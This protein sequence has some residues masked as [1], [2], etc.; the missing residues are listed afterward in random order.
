MRAASGSLQVHCARYL[1]RLRHRRGEQLDREVVGQVEVDDRD[2]RL[3]PGH[4]LECHLGQHRER[5]PASREPARHVVARHVLH[6]AAAGLEQLRP[7]VD[8]LDTQQVI[9]RRPAVD[10][11]RARQV[12]G[13]H[14]P[15]RL[16]AVRSAGGGAHVDRLEGEHL[17]A[18]GQLGLDRGERRAGARRHHELARLI[19]GDAAQRGRGDGYGA[20]DGAADGALGTRAHDLDGEALLGAS[21]DH[22]LELPVGS[23]PLQVAQSDLL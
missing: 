17:P 21:R 22:E 11:P 15:D 18:R 14:R 13:E 4:D 12:G 16:R 19:E 2:R 10:A 9:A 3:R 7:A 6:D 8:A 5:A 23:G 1:H 20:L